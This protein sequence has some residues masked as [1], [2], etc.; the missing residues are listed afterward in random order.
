MSLL[1]RLADLGW[2]GMG[3][4]GEPQDIAGV[5]P[6]RLLSMSPAAVAADCTY[7]E[8]HSVSAALL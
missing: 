5:P 7:L 6:K 3:V 1:G 8:Q 4:C 2:L